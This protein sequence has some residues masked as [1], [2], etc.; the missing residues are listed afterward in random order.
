MRYG[1]VIVALFAAA[2][3]LIGYLCVTRFMTSTAQSSIV[4]STTQQETLQLTVGV[5]RNEYGFSD[6][7]FLGGNKVW[8]VG[9]DGHDPQRMYYSEDAGLNWKA[10][11]ILTGGFTLT[12]ITFVTAQ[13]GWAVG[14]NGTIVHTRNGG[15]TWEQIKRPTESDLNEV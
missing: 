1:K 9:Y 6:V 8:A 12:G 3:L 10:K 15:E 14:N 4:E 7:A 13:E 11:A 5:S 2:M